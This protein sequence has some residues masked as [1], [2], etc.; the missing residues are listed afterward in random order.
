[1][2]KIRRTGRVVNA[3]V[4]VLVIAGC[5]A[6]PA[7]PSRP[8][9]YDF[10]WAGGVGTAAAS[11]STSVQ[12]ALALDDI[13]TAGLAD[14]AAVLYR[15]QYADSQQLRPYSAARWSL[16]P[17]QLVRQR[18]KERLGENRAILGADDIAS[19]QQVDG[20][21]PVILRL[22]LEEFS[23]V[24]ASPQSSQGVL[25]LRASLV[26][27]LP[28]GERLLA[29]RVFTESRPAAT[30]DAP[31]GVAALV[32][33]TDAAAVNIDQWVRSLNR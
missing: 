22:Q 18:L 21:A 23:Q 27:N 19:R 25:R 32:V 28:Q 2:R 5:S 17:A 13:S 4:L 16:P 24:F 26:D 9:T 6:L 12:P 3:L 31:G 8:V 20:R 10:G 1:M 11:A 29:Q 15:L 30:Q 33:A 7:A 14:T